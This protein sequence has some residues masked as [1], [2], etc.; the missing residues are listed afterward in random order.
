MKITIQQ[1]INKDA[2]QS[3]VDKFRELF[4]ESVDVTPELCLSVASEFD[5]DWAARNFLS[6]AALKLYKETRAAALKL[7]EET[8]ATA[9]KLYKETRADACKL[10]KETSAPAWKLYEETCAAAWKLYEETCAAAWK[11]YE[12]TRAAAFGKLIAAQRGEG[13]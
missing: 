13:V 6:A 1:L 5:W 2:C 12:E 8:R 3:Q 9:L 11:L 10:Y 4:G 7:Y